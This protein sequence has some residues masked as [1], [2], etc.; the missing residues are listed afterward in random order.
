M[1]NIGATPITDHTGG[2]LKTVK[3]PH[4][5]LMVIRLC[6]SYPFDHDDE[7]SLD[8]NKVQD[9]FMLAKRTNRKI[10]VC[11]DSEPH[12]IVER[13]KMSIFRFLNKY[14]NMFDIDFKN[15]T[16]TSLNWAIK[17]TYKAWCELNSLPEEQRFN[18]EFVF[19]CARIFAQPRKMQFDAYLGTK[20]K[21]F[22]CING[23]S[24]QSRKMLESEMEDHKFFTEEQ[25]HKH[26]TTFGYSLD[27]HNEVDTDDNRTHYNNPHTEALKHSMLRSCFS[28]TQ[29]FLQFEDDPAHM[30]SVY[31]DW[32]TERCISEKTL[33]NMYFSQPF[34]LHSDCGSYQF[35]HEQ[36]FKTF[37]G[38]LFDESFDSIVDDTLRL[39]AIL[40]E[41]QRLLA[42][43][44][45]NVQ[46]LIK[47]DA[48][49]DVL[50]HNKAHLLDIGSKTM[51]TEIP[52]QQV[53]NSVYRGQ[54]T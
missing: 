35:L 43:D 14:L 45:A 46:A 13:G 30:Q 42:M 2:Y 21:Y 18:V 20:D 41:L 34:I 39:R 8:L 53:I 11:W 16:F 6:G 5:L 50:K 17:D 4:G 48:V 47:S 52:D 19:M 31:G 27:Q 32:W 24:R 26:I 49:V 12:V 1:H 7:N 10:L 15:L 38:I 23:R 36:G 3:T 44:I 54:A 9:F 51:N 33:R 40:S 28:F 25:M 29:D 37:D 22:A